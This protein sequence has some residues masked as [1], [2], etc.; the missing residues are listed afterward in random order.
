MQQIFNLFFKPKI[1]EA[2]YFFPKET[3]CSFLVN[4]IIMAFFFRQKSCRKNR[5]SPG[6]RWKGFLKNG[7]SIKKL[8]FR[9]DMSHSRF[10]VQQ[11]I[12][13]LSLSLSL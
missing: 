10:Y 1:I 6:H 9:D 11:T 8:I 7:G 2:G 13:S 4:E 12:L 3:S 5:V